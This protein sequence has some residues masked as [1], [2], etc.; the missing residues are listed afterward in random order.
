MMDQVMKLHQQHELFILESVFQSK[1]KLDVYEKMYQPKLALCMKEAIVQH[2]LTLLKMDGYSF[3]RK[4]VEN[5]LKRKIKPKTTM[6]RKVEQ[7]RHTVVSLFHLPKHVHFDFTDIVSLYQSLYGEIVVAKE[8]LD[9]LDQLVQRYRIVFDDPECLYEMS[10]ISFMHEWLQ[11]DQV[12]QRKVG[13]IFCLFL[14]TCIYA[15]I[16]VVQYACGFDLDL[17]DFSLFQSALNRQTINQYYSYFQTCYQIVDGHMDLIQ[18]HL[19]S[20]EM[21]RKVVDEQT[22]L[23]TKAQ[24]HSLI[25]TLSRATIEN[26]L[27]ALVE[28]GYIQRLGK[29]RATKYTKNVHPTFISHLFK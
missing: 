19:S 18:Q 5:M 6:E 22:E 14:Y 29:G 16:S 24:I 8:Q 7:Y 17:L 9:Q 27:T 15:N 2:V 12:Y 11:M 3:N 28:H 13:F 20:Y 1:G 21:V 25:P 26:M 4:H 23:F 10:V